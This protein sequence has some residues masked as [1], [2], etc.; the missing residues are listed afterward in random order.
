MQFLDKTAQS[1]EILVSGIA[2]GQY[3]RSSD[4][5]KARITSQKRRV[6][7]YELANAVPNHLLHWISFCSKRHRT[8]IPC[9]SAMVF[10]VQGRMS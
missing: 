5:P 9:S 3:A 4:T 6:A 7:S 1:M 2:L 8:C 10:E